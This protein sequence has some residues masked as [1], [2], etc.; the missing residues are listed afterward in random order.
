MWAAESSCA[1]P[2][3]NGWTLWWF[4]LRGG[5]RAMICIKV[6]YNSS[7]RKRRKIPP[8]GH[9]KCTKCNTL[10][11][12][13]GDF[14]IFYHW[15]PVQ[16]Q[17]RFESGQKLLSLFSFFV[18][19]FIWSKPGQ[20][21]WFLMAR[22]IRVDPFKLAIRCPRLPAKKIWGALWSDD[23][24]SRGQKVRGPKVPNSV[25]ASQKWSMKEGGFCLA[26]KEE[27][28]LIWHIFSS[29]Q[30]SLSTHIAWEKKFLFSCHA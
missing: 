2:L 9:A 28:R 24:W 11:V 10:N 3:L 27:L 20:S 8:N 14:V 25:G 29:L 23:E 12:L 16:T 13:F 1:L 5:K 6:I 19:E 26:K 18:N 17:M 22:K 7:T 30:R 4:G 21:K 15:R